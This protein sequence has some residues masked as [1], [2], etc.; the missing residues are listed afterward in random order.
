M[1]G[2]DIRLVFTFP[3]KDTKDAYTSEIT[4]LA[5][6][7]CFMQRREYSIYIG[8]LNKFDGEPLTAENFMC[9]LYNGIQIAKNTVIQIALVA[10]NVLVQLYTG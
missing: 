1:L 8:T 2:C 7:P 5:L 10:L 4:F 3:P 6:V 9:Y